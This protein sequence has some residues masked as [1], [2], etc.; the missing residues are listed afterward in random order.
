MIE[1][2]YVLFFVTNIKKTNK[3]KKEKQNKEK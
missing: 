2:Y 1:E 3:S